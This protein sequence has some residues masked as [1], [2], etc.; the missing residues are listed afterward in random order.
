MSTMDKIENVKQQYSNDKNLSVRTKLHLK[1][2]TNKQGF[3][4]W[5]FDKYEFPENCRILELGCGNGGQWQDQIENLPKCCSL[6]LSD[7]SKG[8]VD[9][10]RTNYSKCNNISFQQIDIQN[11]T[12]PDET[13]DI[14]IANHMLYHIP[15]LS[16]ALSEV[17]R[18][19]K[20]DGK[21]YSTTNGNGGMR[22]FLH[23]ALKHFNHD[24]DTKAFTQELSF[25]LQNGYKILN[26][27][28]SA[29]KR[30]DFEDSL[31]ITETQDLVD[32][33]KPTISIASYS[34]KE[35]DGL[36]DY[37][38]DIRKED[39]AINIEKE[40]GLFISIK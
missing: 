2:S 18:V 32:W 3:V 23:N 30:M 25:N 36:F 40:C 8:M 21:F 6:T 9:I 22:P 26:G 11:I 35:L 14:I 7:F 34:E 39:G 20:T 12:F 33:I 4:P 1:H 37:F 16:K 29:V 13:F 17:K 31:S 5:L 10:V 19:L 15:D 28:F 24:G 38:E 27:Y